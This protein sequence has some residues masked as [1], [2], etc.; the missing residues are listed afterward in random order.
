[1]KHTKRMRERRRLLRYRRA[2]H[3]RGVLLLVVLSMLVLFLL[4]GATFVVMA[5]S[6]RAGA[7]AIEKSHETSLQPGDRLERA[8]RQVLRDTNNPHSAV[9]Y[10]SLL[11][12]VY[13]TDGFVGHAY[14]GGMK[15]NNAPHRIPPENLNDIGDG[16][17]GPQLHTMGLGFPDFVARYAG[18]SPAN[19]LG[20]SRGQLIDIYMQDDLGL[21][22][23]DA[24]QRDAHAAL[25]DPRNK[26]GLRAEYV[27][28]LELN[29]EGLTTNHGLSRTNGYYNGCLLTVLDGPAKGQT[30]RIVQYDY[31]SSTSVTQGDPRR[32]GVFRFRVMAFS[33][34][35]G[36]PLQLGL[37]PQNG[38]TNDLVYGKDVG[39]NGLSSNGVIDNQD[40]FFG[41]KIMVNGRP[42]NGAG[43]GQNRFA[44]I[45]GPQLDAM[46]VVQLENNQFVGLETALMPNST[47]FN[48]RLMGFFDAAN[49]PGATS[50]SGDPMA[51]AAF[52]PLNSAGDPNDSSV[53]IFSH[54][55]HYT[56][57]GGSDESYD[58]ADFQNMF[59]ALQYPTPRST[60]RVVGLG[61]RPLELGNPGAAGLINQPRDFFVRLEMEGVTIPSFHRPALVNYWFHRMYRAPWLVAAVPDHQDRVRAILSPYGAD[62]RPHING[63]NANDDNAAP[64][65]AAQIVAI[66]RKISLRPLRED[67]PN[68]D[69]SNP[70]SR[71][72]NRLSPDDGVISRM[73]DTKQPSNPENLRD[74]TLTFPFW[75]ATGPWDVD[76][77]NDGLPDSI[78]VD[79]GDPVQRTKDGRFYKPLYAFLIQDMDGRL[80]INAHGSPD[81]FANTDLDGSRTIRPLDNLQNFN[82]PSGASA[83]MGTSDSQLFSSNQLPHGS[84]WGPGDVSLR[85]ILSPDLVTRNP[86]LIGSPL[87]DDYARLF[88]GRKV[89]PGTA[90]IELSSQQLW[91]RYG[92]LEYTEAASRSVLD[93][94]PGAAFDP[95][96]FRV[97]DSLTPFEFYQY[98]RMDRRAAQRGIRNRIDGVAVAARVDARRVRIEQMSADQP[99]AFGS[100]PDLG[101]RYATGV[102]YRGQPTNEAANDPELPTIVDDQPY[103]VNLM[104]GARRDATDNF[105]PLMN[106]DAPFSPAELERILRALDPDAGRLPGRLWN[107]VDAFDPVKL[108]VQ[109]DG[110]DP[111][112]TVGGTSS[113]E[114]VAAQ[115]ETAARRAAITTESYELPTPG[116]NW[117]GRLTY[118]ADGR[119]G[120]AGVDEVGTDG[121]EDAPDADTL[122]DGTIADGDDLDDITEYNVVPGSGATIDANNNGRIDLVE[123]PNAVDAFNAGVDD[124]LVVMGANPP[125]NARMLDYLRYRVTLELKR[126]GEINPATMPDADRNTLTGAQIQLLNDAE[127][128]IN[129]VIHGN[130]GADAREVRHVRNNPSQPT[131][132]SYGGLLAPEV[133]AGLK[134]DLNRPFGDGRDNNGNGIVDEP[135][136]AG[137]PYI[138]LNGDGNWSSSEPYLD[139]DGDGRFYADWNND[140][141][142]N[143]ADWRDFSADG[144]NNP[145]PV[146]DSL[147]AEQLGQ[148]VPFDY[149]A[150]ADA[151]GRG[152]YL[153]GGNAGNQIRDDGR[154]ARQLYARHLYCMM[155]LVADENYLAPFDPKDPQVLHYLDADSE[156]TEPNPAGGQPIVRRSMANQI[157]TDLEARDDALGIPATPQRADTN[158]AEARRQALRKLT[159]RQVAQWAINCAEMRD[160]DGICTPFEYDENPW[161]G[162]NV[163]DTK[164]QAVYPLDGDITTDENYTEVRSA[165]QITRT[166]AL[167][168]PALPHWQGVAP[169]YYLNAARDGFL[170]GGGSRGDYALDEDDNY[171]ADQVLSFEQTRG[172]VWGV[173]RQ[174]L[175]LTEG[176]ALHD[177]R[178]EDLEGPGD[179]QGNNNQGG[180]LGNNAGAQQTGLKNNDMDLDQRL[181]PQGSVH[182]EVYNPASSDGPLP[183]ELYRNRNGLPRYADIDK[184]GASLADN[185]RDGTPDSPDPDDVPVEGVLLDRLSNAAAVLTD[186]N[187]NVRFPPGN[188]TV[189]S[190]EEW[191]ANPNAAALRAPSPVWRMVCI[192]DHPQMRNDDPID[193]PIKLGAAVYPDRAAQNL[194]AGPSSAGR[195]SE[196][197]KNLSYEPE[198]E[199]PFDWHKVG[200]NNVNSWRTQRRKEIATPNRMPDP[201]FPS[202]DSFATPQ[203]ERDNGAEYRAKYIKPASYIEREW[204]FTRGIDVPANTGVLGATEARF[205]PADVRLC[206]PVRP[207]ILKD[208]AGIIPRDAGRNAERNEF[209]PDYIKAPAFGAA[210]PKDLAIY[211]WRF[212]PVKQVGNQQFESLRPAPIMPGHYGVI[213]SAGVEYRGAANVLPDFEGRYITTIGR[214]IVDDGQ[215]AGGAGDEQTILNG[216]V[217][218]QIRRIE[219]VPN[220]NPYLHQVAV[221]MNGG[222]E[223]RLLNP[224]AGNK[225]VFNVTDPSSFPT[226]PAAPATTRTARN[227]KEFNED[228]AFP[229]FYTN[230]NRLRPYHLSPGSTDMRYYAIRPCV[231]IPV[232]GMS[233]SEPLDSYVLR[234]AAMEEK[235]TLKWDKNAEAG[236]GEFVST[237]ENGN[238]IVAYNQPFDIQP[239]L[240]LN[241]TT[242]NYR[243]VHL[244]RL[245]NPLLAWNPPKMRPNGLQHPQH[246]PSRP[247][248]PYR[249]V[250]SMSLDLTAFNGINN[251]ETR[252]TTKSDTRTDALKLIVEGGQPPAELHQRA[253]HLPP[254]GSILGIPG[255]QDSD[256]DKILM[257]LSSQYRG[258]HEQRFEYGDDPGAGGTPDVLKTLESGRVLWARERPNQVVDIL[259]SRIDVFDTRTS[260][261]TN[262]AARLAQPVHEDIRPKGPGTSGLAM[263]FP[264][265]HSL[266]YDNFAVV[267]QIVTK[268]PQ[269]VTGSA[270]AFYPAKVDLRATFTSDL[271]DNYLATTPAY[272]IDIN[273]DGILGDV[274]GNP[275]VSLINRF[276]VDDPRTGTAGDPVD[277]AGQFD[278]RDDSTFPWMVWGDRPFSS[279]MELL[280]APATSSSRLTQDFSIVNPFVTTPPSRYDGFSQPLPDGNSV[281]AIDDDGAGET[282][283]ARLASTNYPFGHLLNMFQ[284]NSSP[285][286]AFRLNDQAIP[287]GAANYHRL[288]D[289][290]HTPSRFVATDVMLDPLL[291]NSL[292]ANL[293]AIADNVQLGDPRRP[294]QAPFNRV[295]KYREPG[296]VNLNTIVGRGDALEPADRWSDVYDGL[297]HRI[298]DGNF[299]N[300]RGADN[301][302]D[303]TPDDDT[304]IGMGHLGPAWRDVALSR[305]G[306]AQ[307]RVAALLEGSG[308]SGRAILLDYSSTTM[309]GNFPTRFANPFRA[310][311][312][313]DLVPLPQLVQTG[314]DASMMRAHPFSPG[315]DG[316]W[317]RPG[318]DA[319][320]SKSGDGFPDAD[321][322]VNNASEA[323]A[324]Y[325]APAASGG[326]ASDDQLLV[327]ADGALPDS[328][329]VSQGGGGAPPVTPLFGEESTETSLDA[330]RNPGVA[331][332]P[333]TRLANLTTSRSG[334][335][336]VWI[337]VGFFE[338]TP[339]DPWIDKNGQP[340][341]VQPRFNNDRELYDL[342]YHDGYQLGRELGSD[343]GD[344]KRFRGFYLIDRTLPVAFKPGE[345]VNSDQT[346]LLE[347]RIE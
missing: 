23:D 214:P 238:A 197:Y 222:D 30:A 207:I 45:A 27:V 321:L 121:S 297:M 109:L 14:A 94:R 138:D 51:P 46:E 266:G 317:G 175:L 211:T 169:V 134:M 302:Y 277:E 65:V 156:T 108:A 236:E 125:A 332:N 75:E 61:N 265:K 31:I 144:V 248:N 347:R 230:L 20:P 194:I 89:T 212:P 17:T 316:V 293:A 271:T 330:R 97:R 67:H 181:R 80:N 334:V 275:R 228:T 221:N 152:S 102:G 160:S 110:T 13:G 311:D 176:L 166:P 269:E 103:E 195:L 274:I 52:L 26:N 243:S 147:F 242:S 34:A 231:A 88:V 21:D 119:P 87:A 49:S 299:I 10:H 115:I 253:H 309:N 105:N 314:V 289:Y 170:P 62:G 276:E 320:I 168:A 73:V 161:D 220:T 291:F 120:V 206:V 184:D 24:R 329:R 209:W 336:G 56:G 174:D 305:R 81:H 90:D 99:S 33:R 77:D 234:R 15:R 219:L 232:E 64:A 116:E 3:R 171:V 135:Q 326:F 258:F 136:E 345:D 178:L 165:A 36:S 93:V 257:T 213:G 157:F 341:A 12:D 192:E 95:V 339:A 124:Y 131:F 172:V 225:Y 304:L 114:L 145:L 63:V 4:I 298:D 155:L 47:F 244:Q 343:T 85:S 280:Q 162:W 179:V 328:L 325:D 281:G 235:L 203:L 40:P 104:A 342:V 256:A 91:G 83:I 239:E 140:G 344:T 224:A 101:S 96:Q 59:L 267:R 111:L 263:N 106:D 117:T 8:L 123:L 55:P 58:A 187:G 315:A 264:I 100:S 1:M 50:F 54:Y 53:P 132:A 86:N 98:P 245:A 127:Q 227:L 19:L 154:M 201:D 249:T 191:I 6:Q 149:T 22:P 122:W 215:G 128:K 163:V 229:C 319:F 158:K 250:D 28:D 185:N 216:S 38:E 133:I 82:L 193:N 2:Q 57:I 285:A 268:P 273:G 41:R 182:I 294:F 76:N 208:G 139:L 107:L 43:V 301:P 9:R 16:F 251:H 217:I 199:L 226:D 303:A 284:T 66:K 300:Y 196:A 246:D 324:Y 313:G 233:I 18:A 340:G 183:A 254:H 78:W 42:Y 35:D 126:R 295:A 318:D 164:H 186:E 113:G 11:R 255:D 118:G 84:G 153:F 148:P 306:Y 129:L 151:N 252:I 286:V 200:I 37:N 150:G 204:Y 70:E 177:R 143:A 223:F 159:C 310:A 288:L 240:A 290:V 237:V 278:F 323:G 79:L 142:A 261:D 190:L 202:F 112:T 308:P 68:F 247:V 137:E 335:F 312:A 272:N 283:A 7:K 322:V 346:I 210:T 331:Y 29:A 262:N 44:G 39:A 338:V 241:H 72:A 333:M 188:N 198:S 307:T 173:E 292:G 279:A 218:E 282:N 327:R 180:P 260:T 32:I 48:P 130:N 60:A 296:K 92:S 5:K 141:N 146:V 25:G 337:T 270:K 287:V 69:G 71:Y 167:P 259:D 205:D 74:D 189:M